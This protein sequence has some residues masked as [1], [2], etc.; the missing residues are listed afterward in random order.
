[1]AWNG[2]PS[3]FA[4]STVYTATVTL[5]AK[6]GYTLQGVTAN[7]FTVAGATATNAANSGVITAVFPA[8]NPPAPTIVSIAAIQG[9]TAPATGGTPATAI[10]ETAQYA[11]TVIWNGNPSTFAAST[12]Y[13][14]TITLAAKS[15]Y[16][17]QGV[18]ANFFTVAGATAT[19]SVNSGV[20]TAV[21][22]ATNPPAPTVINIAAIQ[23]VTAPATGGTP[24]TAI[25]ET[26]QYSGNI[27]WTPSVSGTFNN[28]IQY[29]ARITLTA[30]SGYTLQGVATN[31][32]TVEGATATNT[33]NS[34]VITATFPI[35]IPFIN[36]FFVTN[37]IEWNNA[38]TTISYGGNNRSYTINVSGNVA[39]SGTTNNRFGS[40]TGLSVTLN[41]NGKLYLTSRGSIINIG[42]NQTLFI[43]SEDLTLEGLINGYNGSTIDNNNSVININTGG[44]L[45]FISG[46]ISGNYNSS[47]DGGGVYVAGGT[48]TM[49]GGI[50]S[51]N[52]SGSGCGV[53]IASG[54]LTMYDGKI[55][56]NSTYSI[57]GQGGG[58]Y[59]ARGASFSMHT[60]EISNNDVAYGSSQDCKGGGVYV[61]GTFIM[62]NGIISSNKSYGDGGGVYVYQYVQA[63]NSTG[64][65]RIISCTIYGQNEIS[66]LRNLPSAVSTNNWAVIQRGIFS[67]NNWV[68]NGSL[69]STNNTIRVVNGALQ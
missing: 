42:A 47:G 25:T 59:V 26:A 45:E 3:I 36:D 69:T 9:I 41:G 40:V 19:N 39:V 49:N 63:G 62:Y 24:A 55:S 46:K 27:T 23:G 57:Y 29:V 28:S 30:K 38:L 31:F 51:N 4:A 6:T 56:N 18:T 58:V 64:L 12:Q 22:P 48:F 7:F 61:A 1:M 35:T 44:T 68:S 32:F 16:T 66:S 43:N 67:G 53:Y 13:T 21:F 33:A 11:G 50:I 65:F 52:Y 10:T 54:T 14:A 17:L 20:I 34:G 15:G 8:T 37:S 5:T 60:G 2:N